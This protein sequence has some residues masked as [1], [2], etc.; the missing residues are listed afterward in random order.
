AELTR[1]WVNPSARRCKVSVKH[2]CHL[3]HFSFKTRARRARETQGERWP[4]LS[5][6]GRRRSLE[7]SA[8]RGPPWPAV[9]VHT[10][11]MMALHLGK[12]ALLL[13]SKRLEE[14]RICFGVRQGHLRC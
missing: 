2:S 7:R 8:W 14:C 3:I 13:L 9:S 1:R 6:N 4:A 12:L 10:S 5:S 11:P